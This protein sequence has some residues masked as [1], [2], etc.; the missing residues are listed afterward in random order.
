MRIRFPQY[1]L[2]VRGSEAI[3]VKQDGYP[4]GVFD[5]AG[6]WEEY[7]RVSFPNNPDHNR[8]YV[9]ERAIETLEGKSPQMLAWTPENPS[10]WVDRWGA[11]SARA[12]KAPRK[13]RSRSLLRRIW[14]RVFGS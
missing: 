14:E 6:L 3:R 5:L 7:R 2:K 1:T 12:P 8:R 9:I 11:A 13:K 10:V 4:D